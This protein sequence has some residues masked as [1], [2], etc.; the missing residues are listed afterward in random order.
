MP[1]TTNYTLYNPTSLKHLPSPLQAHLTAP[2]GGGGGGG[3]GGA[4]RK[5][6]MADAKDYNYAY[7]VPNKSH[8]A[9]YQ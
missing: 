5:K 4:G 2:W 3:G 6:E 9:K 7:V 8:R 1:T